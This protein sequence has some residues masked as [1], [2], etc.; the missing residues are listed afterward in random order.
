MTALIC[1]S[2]AYDTVML[3]EG[4][5]K[6]VKTGKVEVIKLLLSPDIGTP[7]DIDDFLV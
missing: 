4:E 3:F 1:G 5:F 6:D 2:I 7:P